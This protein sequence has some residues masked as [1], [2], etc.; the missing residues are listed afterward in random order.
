MEKV[1]TLGCVGEVQ[2]VQNRSVV[3]GMKSQCVSCLT[4]EGVI[5]QPLKRRKTD[6]NP[7]VVNAMREAFEIKKIIRK[8]DFSSTQIGDSE[9][10]YL[11]TLLKGSTTIW[12]LDLS[13]NH[14]GDNGARALAEFLKENQSILALDLSCNQIGESGIRALGEVMKKSTTLL[15]VNLSGNSVEDAEAQSLIEA[16]EAGKA[17]RKLDFSSQKIGLDEIKVLTEILKENKNVWNLNLSFNSIGDK[18]VEVLVEAFKENK[19][20]RILDLVSAEIGDGGLQVLLEG[21]KNDKT[22]LS[23]NFS[24]NDIS[25]A[26]VQ[27]LAEFLRE[28]RVLRA[29]DLS[30]TKIGDRGVQTLAKVLEHESTLLHLNLSKN[31]I[32]DI[33]G[34]ALGKAL[35]T[36]Q[37]LW[38][39][40]IMETFIGEASVK[41][42]IQAL[43]VN[44]TLYRLNLTT[45]PYWS[46]SS[47]DKDPLKKV[48]A[49]LLDLLKSLVR[50]NNIPVQM[51]DDIRKG[52][53]RPVCELQELSQQI[54]PIDKF[55]LVTERGTLMHFNECERESVKNLEA[56]VRCLKKLRHTIQAI[57][58]EFSV[59]DHFIFQIKGIH[60][61]QRHK[62]TKE[63]LKNKSQEGLCEEFEEN[64]SFVSSKYY[65]DYYKG[66]PERFNFPNVELAKKIYALWVFF[67][68]SEFPSWIDEKAD[69][70]SVFT[71]LVSV[72]E[73]KREEMDV[74]PSV[75]FSILEK[76]AK[77]VKEDV[78]THDADSRA[79]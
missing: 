65:H 37:F 43:K 70:L 76:M 49:E 36:N 27:A 48:D 5:F 4:Q 54:T 72:V 3:L 51:F 34:Q 14:I 33:G 17:N 35:E 77:G 1:T 10:Q 46:L 11:I 45:D 53:E 64:L 58:G 12:K 40:K 79:S 13:S 18:G 6:N 21:F 44:T 60:L 24:Q 7:S 78:V 47:F 19:T 68:D 31:S 20:T 29:I 52:M 71:H 56:Y 62:S 2:N 75:S 22:L 15:G 67:F 38:N 63:K 8:L 30:C 69:K 74:P 9:V 26:G 23:L 57:E 28:N 25:D 73:G 41:T 55:S 50:R 59:L 61:N 42:F 32:S 66:N 16:L 39:L